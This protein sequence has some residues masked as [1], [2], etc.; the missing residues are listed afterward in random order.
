M[1]ELQ[2]IDSE[3]GIYLMHCTDTDDRHV[4]QQKDGKLLLT[5]TCDLAV[6]KDGKRVGKMSNLVERDRPATWGF[7]PAD[8][9][10]CFKT[11]V[12]L[13]DY[14]WRNIE[15]AEVEIAKHL[16]KGGAA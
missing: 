15:L 13:N 3:K 1:I 5:F 9:S 6:L 8:G 2:T 4:M 14:H 12:L 7:F 16:L 11:G 10:T